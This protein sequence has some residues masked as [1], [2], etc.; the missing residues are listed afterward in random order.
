M[1]ARDRGDQHRHIQDADQEWLQDVEHAAHDPL[2]LR[3]GLRQHPEPIVEQDEVGHRP[4]GLTAAVHGDAQVGPLERQHVVDAVADHRHVVAAPAQGLDQLLL[5]GGADAAEDGGRAGRRAESIGVQLGQLQPGQNLAVCCQTGLPGERLHRRRAIARDDLEPDPSR[6]E[7]GQS[8]LR[9]RP[10]LVAQADQT[11]R[12]QAIR[13][14]WLAS[15]VMQRGRIGSTGEQQH[16]Q[17]AG[18]P[19]VRGRG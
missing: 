5:L 4:G 7:A 1:H 12:Q 18:H 2:A 16:P 9:L 8:A 13:E 11:Q 19:D 6:R 15:A 14:T 10:Q 17:A 3:E